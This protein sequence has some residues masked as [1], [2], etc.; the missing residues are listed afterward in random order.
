[1]KTGKRRFTALC[2][3]VILTF[4]LILPTTA[5]AADLNLEKTV[6]CSAA[7]LLKTVK[8]PQVGSIGGE[9][10]VIGLARS[11]YEV[12]Q[13]YWDNYY[14]AVED[15][16]VKKQGVLHTKKYTEYSRVILALTAI[17]ADPSNVGGYNLFTPL[18]DFDKTVWQ[19][20]NGPVWALIALDSDN[21]ITGYEFINLGKMMDFIKK[22]DDANEALKKA[23]GSYGRFADASKYIDPRHE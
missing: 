17:G 10:A 4:S 8:A 20:I 5:A 18:G 7:Y 6:S 22:G 19:G 23:K 13:S 16:V 1:M 11:G 9:W 3:A 14:A 2:L 12:P 21:L 15:Y